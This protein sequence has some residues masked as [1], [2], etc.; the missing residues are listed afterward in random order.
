MNF[1][2]PCLLCFAQRLL[3]IHCLLQFLLCSL[4]PPSFLCCLLSLPGC[5]L[6]T[7]SF[8]RLRLVSPCA[9]CPTVCFLPAYLRL[10]Q[11]AVHQL[12][13][14]QCAAEGY[15][16]LPFGPTQLSLPA[17]SLPE[18]HFYFES[19][20]C[21]LI[22][23]WQQLLCDTRPFHFFGPFSNRRL[24]TDAW[25]LSILSIMSSINRSS[26]VRFPNAISSP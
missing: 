6:S 2:S 20:D 21:F 15:F 23:L 13:H 12:N 14:F 25:G 10:R 19:G 22:W 11:R 26:L 1:I 16:L 4:F 18:E 7:F 24:R 3:G 9:H 17:G 8:R 5:Q